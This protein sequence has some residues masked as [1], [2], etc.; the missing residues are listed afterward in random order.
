METLNF[1]NLIQA[2]TVGASVLAGML[3]W[4]YPAFKGVSTLFGLVAL[5]SIINILEESGLTRDLYLLSP[6]FVMLFGPAIYLAIKRLTG[7]LEQ[8]LWLH[9]LPVL[10]LVLMTTQVQLVIA[11]GS[12]WRLAYAFFTATML[13]QYKR[14][15][16]QERSDADDFSVTW[17]VWL[18]LI[19][20]GFNLIDVIRLNT[21]HLIG[22]EMNLLGQG[23][24]NLVWLIVIIVITVKILEQGALP[25]RTII[26]ADKSEEGSRV[27]P[28]DNS[29]DAVVEQYRGTFQ[30]LDK[31][32]STHQWYLKPKLTLSQL[33]ELTGL[34]TRD[35]SRAI[36]LVANQSFNDYINKYRVQQVCEQ[37]QQSANKSLTDLA[38]NA[39]FSSKASFNQVFKQV[40]GTTPS[41][42]KRAQQAN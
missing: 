19:T 17:L 38:S 24:N 22:H 1:V 14:S 27:N 4:R 18:V 2:A 39:G 5:A 11:L 23:M 32:I 8:T 37:L 41:E 42:Y 6:I 28:S 9:L 10:P 13:W 31:L 29:N 33:S 40:M 30:E 21:Q 26:D 36:N 34:Q 7:P 35:I 15:L 12:V 20:A 16:E 25:Y 3:L